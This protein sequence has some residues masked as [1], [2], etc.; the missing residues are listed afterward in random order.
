VI[1]RIML[2]VLLGLLG[3]SPANSGEQSSKSQAAQQEVAVEVV[4][5]DCEEGLRAVVESQI[6]KAT[7]AK[8]TTKDPTHRL[9][10]SCRWQQ[11]PPHSTSF[12][13]SWGNADLSLRIERLADESTLYSESFT[14]GAKSRG[15]AM[16]KAAKRAAS[17]LV[18]SRVLPA[19]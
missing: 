1:T 9:L 6:L 12:Y 18:K 10:L 2:L 17:D 15:L 4:A 3:E 5:N 16:K 11:S 19:K 7:A 13:S 14:E 8:I